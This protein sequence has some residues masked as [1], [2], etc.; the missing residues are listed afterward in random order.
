VNTIDHARVSSL[1]GRSVLT[2]HDWSTH[3]LDTLLG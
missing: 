3:D 2:T 1:A